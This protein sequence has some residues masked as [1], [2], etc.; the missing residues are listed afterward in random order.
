M[1]ISELIADLQRRMEREGDLEV[2][3]PSQWDV[4]RHA[5]PVNNTQVN[6]DGKTSYIFLPGKESQKQGSA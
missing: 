3:V 5:Q 2:R 4:Y 6:F 1:K